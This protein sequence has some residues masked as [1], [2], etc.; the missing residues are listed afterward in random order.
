MYQKIVDKLNVLRGT[1]PGSTALVDVLQ[2]TFGQCS[3]PLEHNAPVT[4]ETTLPANTNNASL[5]VNNFWN[6]GGT[7]DGSNGFAIRVAE[8]ITKLEGPLW[9]M[10][11]PEMI[12]FVLQEALSGSA[13]ATATAGV[14][15]F[16]PDNATNPGATVTVVDKIGNWSGAVGSIGYAVWRWINIAQDRGEWVVIALKGASSGT[17]SA[18]PD[19]TCTHGSDGAPYFYLSSISGIGTCT[20]LN[21]NTYLLTYDSACTWKIDGLDL[22]GTCDF[23]EIELVITQDGS[24]TLLTVTTYDTTDAVQTTA[25]Y[26]ITGHPGDILSGPWTFPSPDWTT[27]GSATVG[28]ASL[29]LTPITPSQINSSECANCP[30]DKVPSSYLFTIAGMANAFCDGCAAW[31]GT[32]VLTNQGSCIY[33][34]EPQISSGTAPCGTA[35]YWLERIVFNQA[36][37]VVTIYGQYASTII[38]TITFSAPANCWQWSNEPSTG[39]SFN[40]F[41]SAGA[42][43]FSMSTGT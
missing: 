34:Y 25:E 8:G 22:G 33:S 18:D 12:Q 4:I 30:D 38:A 1:F 17:V 24:D 19:A 32:Y 21:G 10:H 40:G 6:H 11:Q 13:G 26:T 37:G 23:D 28:G 15:W 20:E 43:T 29:V 5:T 31:D 42:A 27:S 14:T 7:P 3:Q 16:S 41:C 35:P 2:Q 9:A 36:T 39:Q